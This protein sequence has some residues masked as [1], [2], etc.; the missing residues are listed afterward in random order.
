MV[1]ELQSEKTNKIGDRG[2][3]ESIF[4]DCVEQVRQEIK[5]RKSLQQYSE[6]GSLY[7]DKIAAKSF[8]KMRKTSGGGFYQQTGLKT[9]GNRGSSSMGLRK[10]NQSAGQFLSADKQRVIELLMQND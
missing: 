1:S 5:K 8:G 2:E 3:L 6:S 7:A 9:P 10:S 4:L